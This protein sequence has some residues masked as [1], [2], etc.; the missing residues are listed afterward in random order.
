MDKTSSDL[1]VGYKLFR[2]RRN[3]SYGPLFI[4]KTLQLYPHIAYDAECHPTKGF[5]VRPGWHICS[6]KNAPHLSKNGRVWC[7]VEFTDYEEI[8]RPDNQGGLWYIANRMMIL[9]ELPHE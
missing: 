4:N 8:F 6:K 9:H 2:K 3:G 7:L 5:K 1:R